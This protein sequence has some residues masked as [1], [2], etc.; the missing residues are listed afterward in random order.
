MR[1]LFDRTVHQQTASGRPG[2]AFS[3]P[4]GICDP[5][6]IYDDIAW[7]RPPAGRPYVAI[8]MVAT[9]DG[10]TTLDR[11]RHPRPIGSRVDRALMVRLRTRVDAVL[12]GAGTV[13]QSPYYP[14]LAPGARER[15]QAEGLP[16]LPMVVVMSGSGALPL[17]SPLFRDPPRRPL[18]LLGPRAPAEA[19]ERLR[20]VADVRVGPDGGDGPDVRWALSCL[21]EEF[22]VKV[23]LS[24][25]GPTLNY[26]FFEAGCVDELFLTVAPFVAGSAEDRSAVDGPRLLQPFPELEL[27]SAYMHEGELFLR[28]RVRRGDDAPLAVEAGQAAGEAGTAGA[29]RQGG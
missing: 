5:H 4:Q 16:P 29:S 11:G 19:V 26:A 28:Y 8:N 3:E 14:S 22:G 17:D 21:A 23:L 18:V 27:L 12:R 25:G 9:V 13:R 7:P 20:Q 10:K 15:R 24:E 2:A 6:R 1:R